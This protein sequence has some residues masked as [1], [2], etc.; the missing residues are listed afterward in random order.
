MP[1]TAKAG[2][3]FLVDCKCVQAEAERLVSRMGWWGL[4]VV[5]E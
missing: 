4:F 2:K 3:T 1:L 5:D